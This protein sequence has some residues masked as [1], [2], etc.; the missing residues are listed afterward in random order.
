LLAE[1]ILLRKC[2]RCTAEPDVFD[3]ATRSAEVRAS[4]AVSYLIDGVLDP[5]FDFFSSLAT[6]EQST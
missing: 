2:S 5:R 6:H 1:H 4:L 3:L